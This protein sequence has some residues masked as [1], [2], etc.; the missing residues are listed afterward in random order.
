VQSTA[1]ET[2]RQRV[3][4]EAAQRNAAE[5]RA[6]KEAEAAAAEAERQRLE[7]EAALQRETEEV[8]HTAAPL[9]EGQSGADAGV[10]AAAL[11]TAVAV[12]PVSTRKRKRKSAEAAIIAAAHRFR[13]EQGK[14]RKD[15][16]TDETYYTAIQRFAGIDLNNLPSGW[17]R[18]NMAS[19][20]RA[21]G[22]LT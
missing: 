13:D 16:K 21:A 8:A 4:R 5:E 3:E 2:E 1:A 15:F 12:N 10:V 11:E 22:L 9:I 19:V 17:S 14:V 6:R 20:L 18:Q 7:R